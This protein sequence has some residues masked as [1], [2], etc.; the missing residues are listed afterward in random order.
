MLHIT[1]WERAALVLLAGDTSI[2]EVATRLGLPA[3]EAERRLNALF[4]RMGAA[5]RNDAIAAALRR[6]LLP[7]ENS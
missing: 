5:S 6:G 4:G 2:D 1:P 3:A 7:L